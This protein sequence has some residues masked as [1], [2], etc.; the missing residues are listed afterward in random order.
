M[1]VIAIDWSGRKKYAHRHIWAAEAAGARV[2]RLACG[3]SREDIGGWLIEERSKG[4]PMIVG[5]DFAFS[6]PEWFLARERMASAPEL[7]EH[8]ATEGEKWLAECLPPFW[9]RPGRRRLGEGPWLR[10]TD[11]LAVSGSIG[12]KSVFQVGGAGA[13]GTGSIRGMPLLHWLRAAG[14]N[15]WPFDPP[16]QQTVIE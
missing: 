9:G 3:L 8:V 14:W 11:A 4:K 16:G 15:I 1:R 10:D 13:V 12:A 5:L 7:W 2:I 6:M